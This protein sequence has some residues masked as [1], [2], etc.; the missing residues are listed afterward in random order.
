VGVRIPIFWPVRGESPVTAERSRKVETGLPEEVH[1]VFLRIRHRGGA[2]FT[3]PPFL[4]VY[5]V[6]LPDFPFS[7]GSETSDLHCLFRAPRERDYVSTSRRHGTFEMA[8]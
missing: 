4:F 1:I 6:E 7:L 8:D 3:N 2:P 5:L